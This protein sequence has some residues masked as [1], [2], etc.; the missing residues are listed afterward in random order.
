MP[1]E[2][3]EAVSDKKIATAIQLLV[4]LALA[5]LMPLFPLQQITGPLVNALLYIATVML[6]VHNALLIC[7]LPSIISIS[8]GLLP[9]IMLPLIPVIIVGNILLVLM[10]SRFREKNFWLGVGTAS[11]LKFVFIY[12]LASILAQQMIHQDKF[13]KL[14]STM[15]SFPQLINALA[16][17]IIA[18]V[19]LK[20]IKRI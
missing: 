10:F 19:F 9:P 4:I 20:S 7:F 18:W 14:V 16:G 3:V 12:S 13:A 5:A 1:E 17:G 6:G 15:M 8:T 2:R 11:V